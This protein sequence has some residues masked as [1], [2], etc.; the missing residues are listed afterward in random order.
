[1]SFD[2]CANCGHGEDYGTCWIGIGTTPIMCTQCD[3]M[4]PK[5]GET[6]ALVSDPQ[7]TLCGP[8]YQ[9]FPFKDDIP[10]GYRLLYREMVERRILDWEGGSRDSNG[11]LSRI[12]IKVE[13]LYLR[14]DRRLDKKDK[15]GWA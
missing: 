4:V 6:L 13:C 1:M 12:T 7:E 5:K 10:A 8:V 2:N 14:R 15:R 3:E 9:T 11:H